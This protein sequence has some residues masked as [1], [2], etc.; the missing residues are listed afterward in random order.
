M[1]NFMI[2]SV[3]LA[4]LVFPMTSFA[5]SP[6]LV[7]LSLQQSQQMALSNNITLRNAEYNLRL[8]EA[9]LERTKL[10]NLLSASVITLRTAE[11]NMEQARNNYEEAKSK[12]VLED[13]ANAYFQVLEASKKIEIGQFSVRQAE[14]NLAMVSNK[15]SLG[16]ASQLD[17]LKAEIISSSAQLSLAQ[18]E[19]GQ[20]LAIMNLN[21]L[22]GLPLATALNLTDA[23]SA[24]ITQVR[25]EDAIVE[26]LENRREISETNDSLALAQLKWELTQNSYT[27]ELDKAEA[28]IELQIAEL[29]QE[30]TQL[31]IVIEVT[32]LF[33]SLNEKKDNIELTNKAMQERQTSYDISQAQYQRGLIATTDLLDAQIQLTEAKTN[34]LEALFDYALARNA[35]ARALGTSTDKQPA[36]RQAEELVQ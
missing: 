22:L 14:E 18:A 30:N 32:Q 20:T 29:N 27:P 4:C 33:L 28:L 25:V 24:E 3:A 35:F 23:L 17:L 9:A 8:S 5:K 13:I 10:N 2:C 34:S 31:E 36:T 26:A 6:E 1:K 19:N 7:E 11:Y 16:D 15:L 21:K 12:L